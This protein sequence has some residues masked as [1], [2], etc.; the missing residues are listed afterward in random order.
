MW[1]VSL[2]TTTIKWLNLDVGLNS[3]AGMK[4][5]YDSKTAKVAHQYFASA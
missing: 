1:C 3:L 4:T 2:L 5:T